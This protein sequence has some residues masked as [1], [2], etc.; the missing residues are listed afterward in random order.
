MYK[1]NTRKLWEIINQSIGKMPNKSCV[2]SSLR[3][4]NVMVTDP[5]DI[6]NELCNHYSKVGGKLSSLIPA[7]STD[8]TTV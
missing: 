2:I 8:K 5:K 6:A 4:E 1:N 7:P 3:V